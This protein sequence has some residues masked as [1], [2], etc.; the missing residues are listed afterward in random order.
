MKKKNQDQRGIKYYASFQAE[1]D[2]IQEA[3]QYISQHD[4][5]GCRVTYYIP[6]PQIPNWVI[7]IL[8]TFNLYK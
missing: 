3:N 5:I 7:R 6:Q 1:F 4:L 2:T 8:K